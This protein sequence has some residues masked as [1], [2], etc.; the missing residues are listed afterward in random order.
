MAVVPPEL[1]APLRKSF[2]KSIVRLA[3]LLVLAAVVGWF[4]LGKW[5]QFREERNTITALKF[6][7]RQDY[8]NASLMARQILLGNPRNSA[9]CRIMGRIALAQRSPSAL[10]WY[11]RLSELKPGNSACLFELAGTA[12]QFDETYLAENSLQKITGPDRETMPY[13]Q[14]AGA[15]ALKNKQYGRARDYFAQALKLDPKNEMLELNVLQLN[16]ITADPATA[17]AAH[18]RLL[19]LLDNPRL[20]VSVLRSL[21]G[22][23][24]NRKDYALALT[25]A[26]QLQDCPEANLDD[27]LGYLEELRRQHN[28]AFGPALATLQ[29]RSSSD[30]G[31][32][33]GIMSWL[34]HLGLTAES[35]AWSTRLPARMLTQKPV[36]LALAEA[37]SMQGSWDQLRKVAD[38]P[39]W[40]DLDFLRFAIQARV[41]ESGE[42]QHGTEFHNK[43][44]SALMPTRG[45]L[46]A[47]AMLAR[48]L[49]GWGWKEAASEIWWIS[50]RQPSGQRPALKALDRIARETG[51]TRQLYAVAER[52]FELEPNNGAAQNNVAL[53]A[54][55]LNENIPRACRL[56][57]ENYHLYPTQPAIASTQ[58]FAL[59][60]QGRCR[61]SLDILAML[62]PSALQDAS[63]AVYYGMALNANHQN[64]QAKK[65]LQ[66]ALSKEKELL[67]EELS[68]ARNALSQKP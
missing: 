9:A 65:Y 16:L 22:E 52:V 46:Y 6:L 13:Y 24:R 33:Y 15:L 64:S 38:G 57:A 41:L 32:I 56:A 12:L 66:H 50:A 7:E 2:L 58:A 35:L 62:P 3:L 53:L 29:S 5:R 30:S 67:P 47:Q 36:P 26:T 48:L 1:S 54:L 11:Q 63:I 43:L 21:L 23:A 49:D 39:G 17:S 4:G 10:L 34:N 60:K 27:H 25:L 44:D 31:L 18:A 59:Y 8:A 45:N 14:M 61:E 42:H 20:K 68:L 37:Y 55:L 19:Q 51:N 28:P 40:E